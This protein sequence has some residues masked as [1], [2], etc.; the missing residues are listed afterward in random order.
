MIEIGVDADDQ[1]SA[2]AKNP[3]IELSAYVPS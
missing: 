3:R 1:A 2:E